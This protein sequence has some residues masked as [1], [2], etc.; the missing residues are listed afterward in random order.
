MTATSPTL[1]D[2][3]GSPFAG[4]VLRSAHG[5]RTRDLALSLMAKSG[6]PVND[7]AT[8]SD[9]GAAAELMLAAEKTRRPARRG[10]GDRHYQ[11]PCGPSPRPVHAVGIE[12]RGWSRPTKS[13]H[14]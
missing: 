13:R 1:P 3:R 6:K 7:V 10:P 2:R 11:Q 9:A 5:R 8:I 12:A 14:I 4:L